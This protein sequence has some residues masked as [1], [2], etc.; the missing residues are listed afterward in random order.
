MMTKNDQLN[1]LSNKVAELER[2][3]KTIEATRELDAI[4]WELILEAIDFYT[5]EINALIQAYQAGLDYIPDETGEG[6][7]DRGGRQDLT[8]F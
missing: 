3:K 8:P 2:I 1:I 6:A 7:G 4:E 5:E